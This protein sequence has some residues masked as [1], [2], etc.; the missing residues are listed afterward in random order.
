MQQVIIRTPRFASPL[1]SSKQAR[2][3]FRWTRPI[4]SEAGVSSITTRSG[5]DGLSDSA[6][7][8]ESNSRIILEDGKGLILPVANR[9]VIL[10]LASVSLIAVAGQATACVE[11]LAPDMLSRMPLDPVSDS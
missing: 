11:N 2:T 5:P 9:C 3:S 8:P 7:I 6:A 1:F 4:H 10:L